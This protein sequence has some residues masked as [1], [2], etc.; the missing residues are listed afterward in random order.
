MKS[1]GWWTV[2][3]LALLF[4]CGKTSENVE[5]NQVVQEFKVVPAFNPD[6][7]YAFIQKQVDFGPRVPNTPEHKATGQ[8]LMDKFAGWGLEVQGQELTAKTYDGRALE[9]TNII[10]SY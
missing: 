8:W 9:L 7:A 5:S 10:A 2:L 4:S 6:S 3:L 1:K